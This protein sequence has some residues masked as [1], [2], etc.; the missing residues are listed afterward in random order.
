MTDE[1]SRY[2]CRRID[3]VVLPLLCWVYFLQVRT[4]LFLLPFEAPLRFARSSTDALLT[5][6]SFIHL[7]T[8]LGQVCHRIRIHLR[9]SDSGSLGRKSGKRSLHSSLLPRRVTFESSFSIRARS[10]L[11]PLFCLD[12]SLLNG[13]LIMLYSLQYS[14][15]GS[16]GYW[17]QLGWQPFSAWLIV[18]V[19]LR[20]VSFFLAPLLSLILILI[21]NIN[22]RSLLDTSCRSSSRPG[23]SR[24]SDSLFRPTTAPSSLFDSSLVSSK[25]PVS[26]CSP[27]SLS[28][29]TGDLSSVSA[30]ISS[31][32]LPI[33]I[34]SVYTVADSLLAYI[35]KYRIALRVALWYGT[36]GLSSMIGSFL[37]WAL[38]FATG[39]KVSTVATSSFSAWN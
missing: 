17:A 33:S 1:Q 3:R 32:N 5:I 18:K 34:S 21:L 13:R 38:S 30:F 10:G 4:Y 29:G 14:I 22:L 24:W 37:A 28:H 6:L 25:L 11:S 7:S 20:R 31:L 12:I 9:S 35:L 23:V 8:D 27:W 26:L 15:I 36:N 2:V 16:A 39:A 19:S